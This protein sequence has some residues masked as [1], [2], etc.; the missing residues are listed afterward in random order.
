MYL[1]KLPSMCLVNREISASE[2]WLE[3]L[4]TCH[5]ILDTISYCD[6][7]HHQVVVEERRKLVPLLVSKNLVIA[8]PRHRTVRIVRALEGLR[9]VFGRCFLRSRILKEANV[10]VTAEQEI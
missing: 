8:R 4:C 3:P 9:L 2:F 6:S 7:G 5:Q 10:E 1:D